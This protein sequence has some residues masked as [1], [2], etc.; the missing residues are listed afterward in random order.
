MAWLIPLAVIGLPVVEIALFSE[1]ADKIGWLA[2]IGL[3]LLAGVAGIGLLRVQGLVTAA[4][5]QAQLQKG[6]MPVA[7]MFDGLCLSVAGI[8][9]LVPGFFTDILA[10]FLLLAP[11]RHGIRRW[12]AS[13]LTLAPQ[14]PG[15]THGA[16]RPPGAHGPTVIDGDFTI[17]EDAPPPPAPPERRL[18]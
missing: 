3:V 2:T 17:V 6:E 14:G 10:A 9:L 13:R 7:E 12:L 15:A 8:L 11:V 4:R 1:V 18:D 16:D 5:V